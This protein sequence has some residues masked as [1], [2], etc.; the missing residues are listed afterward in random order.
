MCSRYA[1]AHMLAH[2]SESGHFLALSFMDSSVWCFEC[3]SYVDAPKLRDITTR[4]DQ[5]NIAL[6]M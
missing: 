6:L 3:D 1:N 5:K 2:A 4:V